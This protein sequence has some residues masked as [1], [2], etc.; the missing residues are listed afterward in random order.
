MLTFPLKETSGQKEWCVLLANW[1]CI[2]F[3]QLNCVIN[4]FQ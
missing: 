1:S 3:L 4:V 2:W